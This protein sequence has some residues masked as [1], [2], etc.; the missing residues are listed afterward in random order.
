MNRTLFSALLRQRLTSPMRM[1]I[2]F[3][4]GSSS[5]LMSLVMRSLAPIE[6]LAWTLSLLFAAGAIGQDLSSGV[7]QLTFSRP[8]TRQS[9]VVSRWASVVAGAWGAHT[10]LV[11]LASTGM[12]LR[13]VPISQIPMGFVIVES[14]IAIAATCAVI[15]GFSSLVR[16]LGDLALYAAFMIL[17]SIVAQLARAQGQFWLERLCEELGRTVHPEL[18]LSFLVNGG[19]IPWSAIAG[20]SAT[21]PLFLGLAITVMNRREI[22]Y[23]DS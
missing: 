14:G 21:I 17:P 11:L 22:S 3:L 23:G 2:L 13:G 18:K 19:A 1:G 20:W 7:M 4:A 8:L 5:V 9:Y 6:N 10:L 16:G 12:A 15:V